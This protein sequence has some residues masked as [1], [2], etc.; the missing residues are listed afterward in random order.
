MTR[1]VVAF[2]C[3]IGSLAAQSQEDLRSEVAALRSVVE[4]LQ[5]RLDRLES[6]SPATSLPPPAAAVAPP[7]TTGASAGAPANTAGTTVNFL[8]DTYYGYNFNHPIGRVN[9]LRAYD[10]SSNAF[11]LNQAVVVLENAADPARG[12]RWGARLDLQFGQATAT[13]QGNLVNEPRP[14]IYRNVFQAF[15]TYVFPL[16]E[17]LT[18]DFWQVGK[19]PGLRKQL[20]KGSDQLLTLILV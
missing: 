5:A 11:S 8:I 10:V 9:L 3:S 15:G 20:Y 4:K 2:V 6:Q 17:G 14:G 16:N 7:S 19:Q 13:L 12:K 18:V 1:I